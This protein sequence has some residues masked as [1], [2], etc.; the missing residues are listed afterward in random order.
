MLYSYTGYTVLYSLYSIQLYSAIQYTVYTTPLWMRVRQAVL[1]LTHGR[2]R[3][4]QTA[5][6]A[7]HRGHL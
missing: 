7:R 4:I 3:P 2:A 6:G 1:G 5:R